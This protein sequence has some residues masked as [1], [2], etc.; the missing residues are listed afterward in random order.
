MPFVEESKIAATHRIQAD[1][2]WEEASLF[3]DERRKKYKTQGLKRAE[4]N[5]KAW[6]AMIDE[7]PPE[8][9][10]DV[11][12]YVALAKHLPSTMYNI[13][14]PTPEF[15]DTWYAQCNSIAGFA[16]YGHHE[17]DWEG[18]INIFQLARENAPT[19]GARDLIF[20]M[21]QD[22]EKFFRE[23]VKEVFKREL[24]RADSVCTEEVWSEY[25]GML[26]DTYHSGI[27][28]FNKSDLTRTP[29]ST[30]PNPQ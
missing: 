28:V 2:R 10:D 14:D 8:D 19:E 25:A 15:T 13:P 18:A 29:V 4:A 1:G 6:Q 5:E 17:D 9:E 21:I 26:A 12:F 30:Q 22:H 3:R 11:L 23:T 24:M 16:W 20:E 7:F 27:Y